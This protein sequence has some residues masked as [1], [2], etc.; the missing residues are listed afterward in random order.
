ML[1]EKKAIKRDA[2]EITCTELLVPQEHLLRKTDAAVDFNQI[3][4]IVSDLYCISTE[5]PD[6]SVNMN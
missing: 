2:L 1:I 3:F 4:E 6:E 5:I